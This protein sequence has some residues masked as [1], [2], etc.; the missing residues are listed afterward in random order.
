M[1]LQRS[2][3]LLHGKQPLTEPAQLLFGLNKPGTGAFVKTLGALSPLVDT[4]VLVELLDEVKA[5][6][7][8]YGRAD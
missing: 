5:E 1:S 4:D 8:L 2:A 7:I 3:L 6:K